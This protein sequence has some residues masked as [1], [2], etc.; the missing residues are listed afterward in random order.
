MN[1]T[2][3][4]IMKTQKSLGV[5]VGNVI[6]GSK[7]EIKKEKKRIYDKIYHKKWYAKNRKIKLEKRSAY[8]Y[9]NKN[10]KWYKESLAR[11]GRNL[12]HNNFNA[13]LKKILRTRLIHAL[14]GKSKNESALKLLGCN[15]QELWQHLEKQFQPGMTRKN[16]GLWH[17]DHVKPCASFDLSKPEEQKKCFHFSNLQP[18]W[19]EDNF[20]KGTKY[21]MFLNR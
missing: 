1:T 11:N 21:E 19:A 4:I 18:L 10:K 2:K 12:Y 14:N 8:H 3:D 17:I 7:E 20:K 6:A 5:S 13:K 9:K 16:Y 15:T